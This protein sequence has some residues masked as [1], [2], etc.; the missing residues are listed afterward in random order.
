M[1]GL[2]AFSPENSRRETVK[3][4]KEICDIALWELDG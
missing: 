4:K 2:P 3:I 1:L